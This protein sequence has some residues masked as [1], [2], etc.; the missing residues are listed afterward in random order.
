[1]KQEYRNIIVRMPNWLG[2]LVMGTPLLEDLRAA[3]KEAKITAMA[4]SHLA[5]LLCGNPH[6]NEIFS[7]CRPGAFERRKRRNITERIAQG[8]YDLGILLTNSFSSALWFCYGH[9]QERV[10][11]RGDLRTALLTTAAQRP[12]CK[13]HLVTT[14]K[15]LLLPL[16]IPLSET[17]PTLFVT[18]EEKRA[19]EQIL[20]ELGIPPKRTLIAINAAA[21]Y[22]PAKSWLPD[23]FR[24]VAQRL[25]EKKDV[26]IL[27]LGDNAGRLFVHSICHDLSPRAF[28]LAGKTTLRELM[29][30]L[31]HC[32]ALLTIDSGTMH[33]AAA[34]KCPLVAL[35]GSTCDTQTGPYGTGT[36]IHKHVSCS[37]C[38][39]RICPIDFKCMKQIDVEQVVSALESLLNQ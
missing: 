14:Y 39:K 2:D 19:A 25:L 8:K 17:P 32:N 37:P 38:F 18:E 11:F 9:V 30:L 34:L 4:P 26:H 3:Y 23:R 5:P 20:R 1:M 22:G 33:I 6:I 10:G 12:E 35:F 24:A 15:R 29:A 7:F 36:V 16:D 31:S 13:E 21:A 27:F 28:N